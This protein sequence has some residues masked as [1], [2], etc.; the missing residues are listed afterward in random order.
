MQ[1]HAMLILT[2]DDIQ[3]L[4]HNRERDIID[5]V[6]RAYLTHRR[7][8]SSLPQSIFLRFPNNQQDR[9]IALPAYVGDGIDLAG[10]KWIASFPGNVAQGLDRASAT[11]ILNEAQTGYPLALLEGSVISA[12]RTAASAALAAATL[13]H[14]PVGQ[15]A[16]VGCGVIN[17]EILRF[18]LAIFPGLTSCVI[19]DLSTAHAEHFRQRA[20]A[21]FAQ[22]DVTVAPDLPTALGR[23]SLIS[24]ATTAGTPYL[25]DP[26]VFA[27]RSTV[28][29]IS[30]RDLAPQVILAA[31]NVVDDIEHVCRAQTSVHLTSEQQSNRDFIRC[32]LADILEG[33]APARRNDDRPVIFS[34]F[35]LGVLDL[36]LARDVYDR[37]P[38][39]GCGTWINNFLPQAWQRRDS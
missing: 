34:P 32:T 22:L 1:N 36:A 7:G 26:T 11:I 24:F 20:N 30:L 23:A 38:V 21:S 6:K 16:L 29:H 12:R 27:P 14:G 37:A 39:T 25:N 10:I 17:F 4:L 31:D 19:Y 28:L 33:A 18:L 9:I 2:A 8:S 15:V 5:L 35:G 13:H 3:T